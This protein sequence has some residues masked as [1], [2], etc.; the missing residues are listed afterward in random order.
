MNGTTRN[1]LLVS[2]LTA[3][4]LLGGGAALSGNVFAADSADTDKTTTTDSTH[5]KRGDKGDRGGKFGFGGGFVFKNAAEVLGVEEK[6]LMTELRSGKT[7]VE[8]AQG[9]GISQ[10]DLISKLT[11]S[12][13]AGID[14]QVTAG[15]LDSAKAAELKADLGKRIEKAVTSKNDFGKGGKHGGGHKGGFVNKEQLAGLLGLTADEI[16]AQQ[17]AGKTLAEIATSKGISREQLLEKLK[18]AMTP[19]LEKFID[20]KKG[21][22]PEGRQGTGQ[23]KSQQAE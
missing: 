22:K 4:L 10:A 1:R 5:S 15:K 7:L 12:A 16:K 14:A 6:A 23:A 21:D 9:K 19:S 8:I 3:A 20:A 11:A 2:T 18:A 17:E 13:S